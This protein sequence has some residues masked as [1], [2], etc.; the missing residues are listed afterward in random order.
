MR[1]RSKCE[2]HACPYGTLREGKLRSSAGTGDTQVCVWVRTYRG[3]DRGGPNGGRGFVS[4]LGSCRLGGAGG[5]GW[6]TRSVAPVENVISIQSGETCVEDPYKPG[7]FLHPSPLIAN[8]T[9]HPVRDA[10]WF[11]SQQ[12]E[13]PEIQETSPGSRYSPKPKQSSGFLTLSRALLPHRPP[14]TTIRR[15]ESPEDGRG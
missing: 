8:P 13:K 9:Y 1:L 2:R 15:G 4:A 14:P 10:L 12:V 5:P 6:L 7:A 11:P 3:K